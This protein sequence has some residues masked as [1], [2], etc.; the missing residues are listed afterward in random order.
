MY[1]KHLSLL[2]PECEHL[3]R[4]LFLSNAAEDICQ[5]FSAPRMDPPYPTECEHCWTCPRAVATE[6][7]ESVRST[8]QHHTDI[9]CCRHNPCPLSTSVPIGRDDVPTEAQRPHKA[10]LAISVLSGRVR[11]LGGE[12]LAVQQ[13]HAERELG[14]AVGRTEQQVGP[15]MADGRP[16]LLLL[17]H[18]LHTCGHCAALGHQGFAELRDELAAADG[19]LQRVFS[20][21]AL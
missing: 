20:T 3:V 10:H 15:R 6:Q 19:A 14:R 16:A 11:G 7:R 13:G 8:I 18:V 21:H 12:G 4:S 1:N 2:S 5:V 17:Q 9:P